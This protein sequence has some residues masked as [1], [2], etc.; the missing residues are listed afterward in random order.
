MTVTSVSQLA[1]G[2]VINPVGGSSADGTQVPM[3]VGRGG[4]HLVSEVHGRFYQMAYRGNLFYA[5]S[6][7][8]GTIIPIDTD[9][10]AGHYKWGLLNPSGSNVNLELLQVRAELSATSTYIA[11]AVYLVAF[12]GPVLTVILAGTTT[13]LSGAV[14]NALLLGGNTP[15]SSVLSVYT[16]AASQ[17][18]N[19]LTAIGSFDAITTAAGPKLLRNFDGGMIIPPGTMIGVNGSA[20]Q[21]SI[22]HI[23]FMY[24]EVPV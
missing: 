9:T 16:V 15:K 14:Q 6:P 3:V 1:F 18:D 24:A 2:S 17:A 10:T 20:A 19:H 5:R 22:A 23:E 11:G 13:T 12:S 7:V 4:D 21:T 8:A